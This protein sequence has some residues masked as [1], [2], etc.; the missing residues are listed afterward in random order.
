MH[1]ILLYHDG[2]LW[3]VNWG[4]AGFYPTWFEY[5]G[6]QLAAQK[7]KYPD[8]WQT[9]IKFMVEPSFDVEM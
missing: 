6:M 9:A 2:Q 1:N 4:W 7:D 5:V 8:D 3:F